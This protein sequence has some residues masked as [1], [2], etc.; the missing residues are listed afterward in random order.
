V[1][2][3]VSR[4]SC[5]ADR[6]PVVVRFPA[7]QDRRPAEI[8]TE[9]ISY[10]KPTTTNKSHMSSCSANRSRESDAAPALTAVG[11]AGNLSQKVKRILFSEVIML[12]CIGQ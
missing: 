8:E 7:G 11:E 6:L 1:V 12:D 4:H 10:A 3:L 5:V 9:V 2:Q